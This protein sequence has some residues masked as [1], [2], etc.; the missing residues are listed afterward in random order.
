MVQSP[1][2]GLGCAQVR[3]DFLLTA[4]RSLMRLMLGKGHGASRRTTR[5]RLRCYEDTVRGSQDVPS[6]PSHGHLGKV[7]AFLESPES[8]AARFCS[9]RHLLGEVEGSIAY[10]PGSKIATKQLPKVYTEGCLV[11]SCISTL[12]YRVWKENFHKSRQTDDY[13][14]YSLI[15]GE[16]NTVRLK[17][18][19]WFVLCLT[20]A[21]SLA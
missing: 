1:G 21:T 6:E 7:F 2:D 13:F 8:S 12:S 10:F 11:I 20:W 4:S 5:C 19:F 14:S 16:N 17:E 15:Y 3:H 9:L 18:T